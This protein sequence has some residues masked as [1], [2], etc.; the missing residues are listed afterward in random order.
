MGQFTPSPDSEVEEFLKKVD[1]MNKD[2]TFV[3]HKHDGW[4]GIHNCNKDGQAHW[5]HMNGGHIHSG[6]WKMQGAIYDP[7]GDINR[8]IGRF[9]ITGE[10]ELDFVIHYTDHEH[11]YHKLVPTKDTYIKG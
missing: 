9:E 6:A 11:G 10:G 3:I 5:W 8:W 1:F 7:I 2:W 4:K